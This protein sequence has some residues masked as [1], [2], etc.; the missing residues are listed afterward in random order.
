MERSSLSEGTNFRFSLLSGEG[1]FDFS[2]IRRTF[3]FIFYSFYAAF[4][5]DFLFFLQKAKKKS[6]SIVTVFL[7]SLIARGLK[8][9]LDFQ[10]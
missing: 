1:F 6:L 8:Q 10:Y 2:F 4:L 7:S 5:F 3:C 9:Y